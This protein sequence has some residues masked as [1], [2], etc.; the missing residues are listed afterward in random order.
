MLDLHAEMLG[1]YR[2]NLVTLE[3]LLLGIDAE[4]A[5]QRP[6][7]ESW[8]IVEVVAH[9]ADTEERAHARVRRMLSEDEPLIEGYDEQ[10]LAAEHRYH[11]MNLGE[12][13][14]RFKTERVA[15]L[16]TLEALDADG[17]GR[18]AVHN[19]FGP[20]TIGSLTELMVTHDTI[21]LA[22]IARILLGRPEA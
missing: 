16:A 21:H 11:E 3:A 19:E 10:A 2:A 20:I 17:W 22:Q 8:S 4:R 9:L 6:A 18:A 5:R 1:A 7:A 15:Q 13:L 12:A 14:A